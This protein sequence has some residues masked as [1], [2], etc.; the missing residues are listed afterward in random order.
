MKC[1]AEQRGGQQPAHGI[2]RRRQGQCQPSCS[3]I[4][5]AGFALFEELGNGAPGEEILKPVK[6]S[7]LQAA[8]GHLEKLHLAQAA[9]VPNIVP[10]N[11][12]AYCKMS[13]HG[14]AEL[15]WCLQPG[16]S[17]LPVT[18]FPKVNFIS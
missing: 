3:A 18:Q 1:Q 15:P 13:S 6:K 14:P 2:A 11:P 9:S 7:T 12:T 5:A 8:V 10:S 17:Q 4:C 16:C